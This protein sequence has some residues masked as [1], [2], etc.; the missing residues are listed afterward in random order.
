[1]QAVC[2]YLTKFWK[3]HLCFEVAVFVRMHKTL[4]ENLPENQEYISLVIQ[5]EKKRKKRI[6]IS[7]CGNC[8]IFYRFLTNSCLFS[9]SV[10]SSVSCA[11][12][13]VRNFSSSYK[14]KTIPFVYLTISKGIQVSYKILLDHASWNEENIC[15]YTVINHTSIN[16]VIQ[17]PSKWICI[18][19]LS[20]SYVQHHATP[21]TIHSPLPCLLHCFLAV[22]LLLSTATLIVLSLT[23]STSF[24]LVTCQAPQSHYP[25][26]AVYTHL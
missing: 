17:F 9:S 7:L 13:S 18:L 26:P 6:H 21:R 24:P 14:S 22:L 12:K 2:P 1:M 20:F 19:S 15:L 5:K 10:A 23:S 25:W 11:N 8:H 3:M 16:F 4:S